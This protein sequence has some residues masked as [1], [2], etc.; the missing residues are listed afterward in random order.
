MQR[1]FATRV[2]EVTDDQ[3]TVASRDRI[4]MSQAPKKL[5]LLQPLRANRLPGRWAV[6]SRRSG[7]LRLSCT[8][9]FVLGHDNLFRSQ[10]FGFQGLFV[11]QRLK[12]GTLSF[13]L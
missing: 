10:F 9:L 4:A 1:L 3:M 12:F 6:R 7:A 2:A 11:L 8:R 5:A 13:F